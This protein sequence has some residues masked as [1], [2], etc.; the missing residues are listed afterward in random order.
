MVIYKVPIKE[1]S[2]KNTE[3]GDLITVEVCVCKY[4]NKEFQK[5]DCDV[6]REMNIIR[7]EHINICPACHLAKIPMISGLK[8]T[9]DFYEYNNET[10]KSELKKEYKPDENKLEKLRLLIRSRKV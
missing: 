3:T 5:Y 7:S 9:S 1:I 8:S 4:C 6:F 10:K 2:I